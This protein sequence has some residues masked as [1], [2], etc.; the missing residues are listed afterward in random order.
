MEL[1][2]FEFYGT[3]SGSVIIAEKDKTLRAYELEE[4][5][6]TQAMLEKIS[7]FYPEAF[8][9]LRETYSAT[10]ANKA[11]FDYKMAHRFI[12]CNFS[13]YD[14]K[15]DIDQ[16]GVFKFE[17][18]PCPMRGECKYCSII[19][20]PKFNAKLSGREMQVMKL[21][22]NS[23]RAE[24]IADTLFISIETVRKHKRNSL[25]KLGFHSLSEFIT[26]ASKNQ[27]FENHD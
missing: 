25:Q 16:D 20:N 17:F 21:Y 23:Y 2:N 27:I 14:N 3:P 10:S 18:I 13:E 19:C 7:N 6:F 24:K 11:Y 5:G 1:I 9:A 26:Y 12:R 15:S 4:K 8:E 22:S